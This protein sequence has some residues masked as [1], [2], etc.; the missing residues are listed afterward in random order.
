MFNSSRFSGLKAMT[1]LGVLLVLGMAGE[2]TASRTYKVSSDWLAQRGAVGIPLQFVITVPNTPANKGKHN[3]P[4]GIPNDN[5]MG[6]GTVTVTGKSPASFTVPTSVAV[7]DFGKLP[8]PGFALPGTANIQIT[9][10][11]T[12]AKAP[13]PISV[14]PQG[15][16]GVFGKG[17]GPGSFT[18]CPKG[19][20]G[21]N[22]GKPAGTCPGPPAAPLGSGRP[23]RVVY[24]AGANTFGGTMRLL[25]KGS[26]LVSRPRAGHGWPGTTTP[27]QAF[28]NVFG[29]GAGNLQVQGAAPLGSTGGVVTEW[30]W[31]ANMLPGGPATQ[32]L[33]I[34]GTTEN[35]PLGKA[36]PRLTTSGKFTACPTGFNMGAGGPTTIASYTNLSMCTAGNIGMGTQYQAVT[37]TTTNTGF[38]WTTG[39]VVAQQNTNVPGGYD[40]FTGTGSDM[41]SNLGRGQITMVAGGLSIR[42]TGAAT[43]STGSM[44]TFTLVL[45]GAAPTMSKTGFAAAAALMVIAVGYAFRRRF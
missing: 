41:R 34:P 5:L 43:L 3:F 12:D 24:T 2:A 28:H 30:E 22:Q 9:T 15:G 7:D 38:P 13:V 21:S 16:P 23:G 11:F 20:L 35:I 33:I 4:V 32:P 37:A 26:G 25:L 45:G 19:P 42:K 1:I 39:M 17:G 8:P 44:D 18:F 36:G 31:S 27:F 40:Y 29:G 14:K 10:D 6:A